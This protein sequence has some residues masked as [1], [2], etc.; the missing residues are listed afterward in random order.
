MLALWA[1]PCALLHGLS[2]RSLD[3]L[4]TD[5]IGPPISIRD[6]RPRHGEH[7][8]GLDLARRA[9]Q[10][11]QGPAVVPSPPVAA[12]VIGIGIETRRRATQGSCRPAGSESVDLRMVLKR[13]RALCCRR[14]GPAGAH[15]TQRREPATTPSGSHRRGR[16]A[17]RSADS[18]YQ[19][20]IARRG[21][22]HRVRHSLGCW[23]DRVRGWRR[24]DDHFPVASRLLPGLDA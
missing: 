21:Q 9:R 23:R 24:R 11:Q 20:T 2:C 7:R 4:V 10:R 22:M 5:A 17:V 19:S 1:I 8:A 18:P 12:C 16:P 6:T 15:G 3:G 13:M 14:S